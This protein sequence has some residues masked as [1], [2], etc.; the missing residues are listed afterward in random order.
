MNIFTTKNLTISS[1]HPCLIVF[2]IDQSRSMQEVF[3]QGE[4]RAQFVTKT[5]NNLIYEAALRCIGSN[6]DL[7]NRFEFSV[8]GYGD[9]NNVQ[10]K[11]EGNLKGKW[12]I[13]IKTLFNNPLEIVNDFPIWI[14]PHHNGS[15][16]MT[17]AFE[18]AKR[19]C[20]DWINFS[21][22]KDCHPP[23]II[24]ITD[25]EANDWGD[26]YSLLFDQVDDIKKLNTNYGPV[27]VFNIHISNV[28][29]NSIYFP[30]RI[31][32]DGSLA[33]VM[34]DISSKLENNM[35]RIAQQKGYDVNENSKG[36]IFNGNASDL[37]NFLNIGTPQ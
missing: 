28:N 20:K 3:E 6:G 34:Y 18:N 14:K 17:R 37:I 1:T 11:W 2:L 23:I 15:T 8:I 5:V 31:S 19:L 7:Q 10:S 4:S 33:K 16:P 22:H 29:D 25:G 35:L 27:L 32:I 9:S 12:I 26:D 30:D 24:N 36:Y 21:N 13:K